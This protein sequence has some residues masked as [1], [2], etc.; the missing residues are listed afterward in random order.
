[1]SLKSG[2][3]SNLCAWVGGTQEPGRCVSLMHRLADGGKNTATHT[4]T[5]THTARPLWLPPAIQ[6]VNPM[7]IQWRDTPMRTTRVDS[8]VV[9]DDMQVV[10][11]EMQHFCLRPARAV[12]LDGGVRVRERRQKMGGGREGPK[13]NEA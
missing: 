12:H 11:D 2:G 10:V 1:M 9:L 4:P 7:R 5:P 6:G 8:Q 3:T 13:R